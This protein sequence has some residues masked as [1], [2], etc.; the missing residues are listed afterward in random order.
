MEVSLAMGRI[1]HGNAK[2]ARQLL[3]LLA[4]R[5]LTI[6]QMA[7]ECGITRSAATKALWRLKNE[8]GAPVVCLG[9]DELG[10]DSNHAPELYTILLPEGRVCAAPGCETLL[11]RRNP[12]DVCAAH[13]GWR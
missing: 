12:S 4:G 3:A 8:M 7:D 11:S 2:R 6:D 5:V 13:G 1:E 10:R 9:E